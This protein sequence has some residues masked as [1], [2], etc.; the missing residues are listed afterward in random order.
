MFFRLVSRNSRRSRKE[1]GLFFSSL[2]MSAVA[3]YIILSFSRQDIMIF[4]AKMESQAVDRILRMIPLFYGVTLFILFFL[5]YYAGRFQMERRRHEFGVYLMMG[6]RRRSLFLMLL[7]EDFRSSLLALGLGIPA[8]VLL[9]ELISLITVRLVGLDIIDHRFTFSAEAVLW[10][11]GGFLFIKLGAFLLLSGRVARQQIGQLLAEEPAAAG[12]ELP[13]IVYGAELLAGLVCVVRACTM[14]VKGVIW[15]GPRKMGL[16]FLLGIG[17]MMLFFFGLRAA[18]GFLAG[19][20]GKNSRLH[21]FNFRQLQESVIR[22]SG[23]LAVSTLLILAALCCCGAGVAIAGYYGESEANVL[24]YTLGGYVQ[25][26]ETVREALAAGGLEEYFSELFEVRTGR[27]RIEET[28]AETQKE[29]EESLHVFHADKVVEA[30][31]RQPESAV[32]DLLINHL[33]YAYYPY[34]ISLSGYNRLLETA[35]MPLLELGQ[36]ELG[37]YMDKG[38]VG[39]ERKEVMDRVLEEKPEVELNGRTFRLAGETQTVNIVTDRFVAFSFALILPDPLFDFFTGG[40]QDVYLNG[41]LDREKLGDKS[42]LGALSEMNE[43][44]D[45]A[46]IAYESY[47]QNMG[48]QLFFMVSAGYITLYLA[49]IFLIIANT[50]LGVQFLMAQRRSGRRYRILLCL[51]ADQNI[52][53]RAVGK[54]INWYFGMPVA[55]ALL[56]SLFGVRGLLKGLVP[57]GA[58]DGIG[59]MM[60]ISA[61]MIFLLFVVEFLYIKAVK[62]AGSRYLLSLTEPEREE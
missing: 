3:F 4:L 35:G 55:A 47:L 62:R 8:A 17:G 9:S 43:A 39:Q 25:S 33:S 6:M 45:R 59:E 51:G 18:V 61:A 29:I 20:E 12:R 30:L 54:Q 42:L 56:C 41:V 5:I 49:V 46:G 44:L 1:N 14:A 19:R 15:S 2:L 32:R 50:V 57:T 60:W 36:D 38:D 37:V 40:E 53:C 24:D 16:M 48:R 34:L 27:V 26:P 11:V 31:E 52:L 10:T 28:E 7:A 21:V 22:H 23:A 13:R 58:Q